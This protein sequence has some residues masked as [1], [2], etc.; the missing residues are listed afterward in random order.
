[1]PIAIPLTPQQRNQLDEQIEVRGLTRFRDAI[2][3]AA[4]GGVIFGTLRG[5]GMSEDAPLGASRYG[6]WPDLPDEDLWPK[7][8]DYWLSFVAQLNLADLPLPSC[9]LPP[10]MLYVFLADRPWRP[11]CHHLV[12]VPAGTRLERTPAPGDQAWVQGLHEFQD[13]PP[14]GEAPVSGPG[15][16]LPH[17]YREPV[18][19]ASVMAYPPILL[20]V[21]PVISLPGTQGM[22]DAGLEEIART[23]T[24]W[25]EHIPRGLRLALWP[26]LRWIVPDRDYR[27]D[28]SW[29]YIELSQ[30]L[31]T[32]SWRTHDV[33][34]NLF[35]HGQQTTGVVTRDAAERVVPRTTGQSA[36]YCQAI[37]QE[38]RRWAPLIELKVLGGKHEICWGCDTHSLEFAVELDR[39]E[40]FDFTAL[41]GGLYA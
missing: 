18:V 20:Q 5:L 4:T 25:H 13:I 8:G 30:D 7:A 33:F 28:P 6:G 38:Q 16:G 39:L 34:V 12:Y 40:K 17:E 29:K 41:Q 9:P 2:Q 1:M 27:Q 26:L 3:Q 11:G 31:E 21:S 22:A 14:R 19:D 15:K 24:R 37:A 23:P 32:W 10:G 36:E 35:G